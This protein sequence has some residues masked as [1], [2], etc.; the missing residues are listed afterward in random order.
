VPVYQR[1]FFDVFWPAYAAT[2]TEK[3]II[4]AWKKAGVEPR[5]PSGILDS[6]REPKHSNRPGSAT[7]AHSTVSIHVFREVRRQLK[8]VTSGLDDSVAAMVGEFLQRYQFELAITEHERDCYKR[9]LISQ[10]A[11][12]KP[13]QSLANKAFK[14]MFGKTHLWDEEM[15]ALRNQLCKQNLIKKC[16]GA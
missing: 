4:S 8:H 11:K 1:E 5:D 13:G 9:A 2:F 15:M 12:A 10:K 14:E 16:R 3:N 6:V 7:S